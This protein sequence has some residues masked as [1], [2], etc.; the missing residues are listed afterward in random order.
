MRLR[1][2]FIPEVRLDFFVGDQEGSEALALRGLQVCHSYKNGACGIMD[3]YGE[4]ELPHEISR[5]RIFCLGD[6][7]LIMEARG[8]VSTT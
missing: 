1:F 7:T 2:K 4:P 3:S 6:V 8:N 5:F